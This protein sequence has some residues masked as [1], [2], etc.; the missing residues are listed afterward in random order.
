MGFLGI[1]VEEAIALVC[2]MLSLDALAYLSFM[3][4][5]E[6]LLASPIG[7]ESSGEAPVMGEGGTLGS[8]LT[9]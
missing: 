7:A 4:V 2:A 3:N 1:G 9:C 6:P 5:A 8:R